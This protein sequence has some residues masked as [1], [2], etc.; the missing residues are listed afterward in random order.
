MPR[1]LL[2]PFLGT[3]QVP[4]VASVG[5]NVALVDRVFDMCRDIAAAGGVV[6]AD[7]ALRCDVVA[8]DRSQ[9]LLLFRIDEYKPATSAA[10][11]ELAVDLVA[12]A[13]R[14]TWVLPSVFAGDDPLALD[15]LIKRV[16]F[17]AEG[18]S[19]SADEDAVA[20]PADG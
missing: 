15:V 6:F 20:Q 18:G 12:P 13:G 10:F 4:S 5:R 14:A 11:D 1:R 16:G 7:Q 19:G 2:N 3:I 17:V 8:H 9:S